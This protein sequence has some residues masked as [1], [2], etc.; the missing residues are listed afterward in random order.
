MEWPEGNSHA[1]HSVREDNLRGP[2][3]VGCRLTTFWKRPNHGDSKGSGVEAGVKD[4]QAEQGGLSG[5]D[6]TLCDTTVTD[7][8]HH[9][10]VKTH[11]MYHTKR[12]PGANSGLWVLMWPRWL[13]D[14]NTYNKCGM[15]TMGE[16][17][18][19]PAGVTGDL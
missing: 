2:H 7:I 1:S 8:C 19:V 17:E 10:F 9:A 5:S 14:G 11:R 12:D 3:T 18:R 4:E 13:T 16:T 6:T 15:L